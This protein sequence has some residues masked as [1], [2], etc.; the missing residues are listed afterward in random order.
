MLIQAEEKENNE[1]DIKESEKTKFKKF[2]DDLGNDYLV[3][4]AI[5]FPGCKNPGTIKHYKANKVFYEKNMIDEPD[6][7]DDEE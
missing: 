1:K 2:A 6:E 4:F 5:G 7:L 3:A